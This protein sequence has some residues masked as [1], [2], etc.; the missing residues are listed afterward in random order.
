MNVLKSAL[1]SA[2]FIT[3]CMVQAQ[4]TG[5]PEIQKKLDAFIELT[6][7]KK[8]DEAF[9]LMYPKMFKQVGKQEL[10]NLMESMDNDGLSLTVTN[11]RITSFSTPFVEGNEKFVRI[12]YTA[13]MSMKVKEG[14]MYDSPKASQAMMQQFETTYNK[15]NVRWNP[16]KK[17]Y[18]IHTKKA[19]M[20]I[21][22]DGKDWY[23]V[24]IN[25][26]QMELMRS[27]FSDAVIAALITVE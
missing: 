11:R 14:G 25:T 4:V 9:D 27:L 26:D 23:L 8:Y 7:E 10:V 17:E 13:D 5:N 19:M 15:E 22:E 1:L 12:Q 20:A 6:N 2:F 16:D 21:Q 18:M 3:A 24:E